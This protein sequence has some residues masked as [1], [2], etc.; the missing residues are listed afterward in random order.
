MSRTERRTAPKALHRQNYLRPE[1]DGRGPVAGYETAADMGRRQGSPAGPEAEPAARPRGS[2]AQ[3]RPVRPWR[4]RL[5][6]EAR[7]PTARRRGRD[8][9]RRISDWRRRRAG[10]SPL[11]APRLPA[12]S[13]ILSSSSTSSAPLPR[14]TE[15][16]RRS[17]GSSSTPCSAISA[18]MLPAAFGA[19]A[20]SGLLGT[21]RGVR[22]RKTGRAGTPRIAHGRSER[23]AIRSVDAHRHD[24]AR[25]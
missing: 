4:V 5:R 17:A 2:P 12:S 19:D 7:S 10:G 22:Q 15:R 3:A 1:G 14:C 18:S 24:L 9:R 25:R 21:G 16:L 11:Q 8:R 23:G 13:P 6:P 20:G